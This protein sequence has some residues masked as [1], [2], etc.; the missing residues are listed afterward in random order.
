MWIAAQAAVTLVTLPEVGA[1][2]VAGP[3]RP[4]LSAL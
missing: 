1:R 2:P 4:G 3:L